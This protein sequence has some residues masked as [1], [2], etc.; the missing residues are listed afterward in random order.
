MNRVVKNANI[1]IILWLNI[2]FY[3]D[4]QKCS[5]PSKCIVPIIRSVVSV[6]LGTLLW[7]PTLSWASVSVNMN[8]YITN[9]R[10]DY[11]Q[12]VYAQNL[13]VRFESIGLVWSWLVKKNVEGKKLAQIFPKKIHEKN[14]NFFTNHGFGFWLPSVSRTHKNILNK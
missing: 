9:S 2:E 1:L 3:I 6:L 10:Q 5:F 11:S 12:A 14:R 7:L 8:N 4:S 13:M